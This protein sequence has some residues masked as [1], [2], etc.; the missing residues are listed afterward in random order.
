MIRYLSSFFFSLLVCLSADIP[1][2]L[3]TEFAALPQA[4]SK[5]SNPSTPERIAL[6]KMLYFEPRISR[7]QK[8]SCNSCHDLARLVSTTTLRRSASKASAEIATRLLSSTPPPISSSSGMAAR[9]ML[10]H[11]PAAPS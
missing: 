3:L 11:R 7:D 1:A 6:G 9:P 2:P 10:K 5:S 8:I 4:V